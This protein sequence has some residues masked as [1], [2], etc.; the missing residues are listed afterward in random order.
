M[1]PHTW[2]VPKSLS[3]TF[4]V[5]PKIATGPFESK[6]ISK[7]IRIRDGQLVEEPK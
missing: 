4:R 5:T 2:R 3:G 7:T 1:R 6:I